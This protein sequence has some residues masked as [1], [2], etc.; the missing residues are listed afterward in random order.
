M[1]LIG[2]LISGELNV[3]TLG[4]AMMQDVM[5]SSP[6]QLAQ[7]LANLPMKDSMLLIS[8]AGDIIDDL[9]EK[10]DNGENL[11]L[12]QRTFLDMLGQRFLD[13]ELEHAEE[14]RKNGLIPEHKQTK[15]RILTNACTIFVACPHCNVSRAHE[16][17]KDVD[18]IISCHSCDG[19]FRIAKDKF[20]EKCQDDQGD[21]SER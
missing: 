7:E 6:E 21:M 17:S 20:K 14:K 16:V 5:D 1:S 8:R 2:K 10:R 9:K 13:M 4:H 19:K 18:T 3:D 11:N 12:F 15:P